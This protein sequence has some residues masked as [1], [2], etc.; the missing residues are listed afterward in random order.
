[1]HLPSDNTRSSLF[2]SAGG[3]ERAADCS[4]IYTILS[5]ILAT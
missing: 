1:M 3:L 2:L 4:E 5:E